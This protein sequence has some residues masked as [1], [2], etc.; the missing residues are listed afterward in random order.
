MTIWLWKTSP[1]L[2]LHPTTQPW[3]YD[4]TLKPNDHKIIKHFPGTY[5]ASDES[6]MQIRLHLET[7]WPYDY[8][9]YSPGLHLHPTTQPCK[10]DFTLKPNDHM[11][12]KQKNTWTSPASEDSTMQIRFHFT[13]KWPYDYKKNTWTSPASDDSTM[14]I[15]LHLTTKWPSEHTWLHGPR[16]IKSGAWTWR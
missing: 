14:Q 5:P 1:G 10:Y 16:V 2:H 7:K 11:I 13:S 8:K 12:I 4:F 6:T 9:K 15:Q 3:K